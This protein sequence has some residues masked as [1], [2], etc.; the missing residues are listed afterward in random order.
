MIYRFHFL[1]LVTKNIDLFHD[2]QIFCV[3]F[4][5]IEMYLYVNTDV[6]L[7][8]HRLV[9]LWFRYIIYIFKQDQCIV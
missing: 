2:I 6:L 1:K 3:I 7:G 9:E 5:L 4:C 8:M